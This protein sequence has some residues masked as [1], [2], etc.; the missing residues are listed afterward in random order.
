MNNNLYMKIYL[1]NMKLNKV[2]TGIIMK[3][4]KTL[5]NFR[6]IFRIKFRNMS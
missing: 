3:K 6:K 5:N 4:K 1:K 2:I